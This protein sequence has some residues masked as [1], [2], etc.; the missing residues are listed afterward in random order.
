MDGHDSYNF[1]ELIDMAIKNQ[2]EIV[3]LPAHTSN[4]L[5]PCNQVEFMPFIGAYNN[6]AQD[7]ISNHPGVITNKTNF[8]GLLSK[9]LDKAIKKY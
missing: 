6:A 7:V 4:W 9:V 5:Q 2:I 3:K 8:T 1:V